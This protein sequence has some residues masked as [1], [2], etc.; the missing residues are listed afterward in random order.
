[1]TGREPV[2]VTDL[3]R[4]GNPALPW[5]RADD[6]L[7]VSM[8]SPAVTSFLGTVRPDGRPCAAGIGAAWLDGD[9][10]FTS[11]PDAR[12]ARNLAANPACTFSAKL[13]GIDLVAEGEAARVTDEETLKR[14]AAVYQAAGWP[15]EVEGAAFT[16]PFNAPSAGP[17]PWELYRMRIRTVF[18][19]ATAEPY[20]ATRW[21]FED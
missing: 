15:A 17:P 13:E 6:A 19:V 14:L 10:Y 5:G 9:L 3:D 21:R 2:E 16:A 18:G 8:P 12:K 20:G 1:M 4:Y 7:R 11:S